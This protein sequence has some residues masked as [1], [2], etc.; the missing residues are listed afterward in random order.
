M[1]IQGVTLKGITV[2][3][4]YIVNQNLAIRIDANNSSLWC[5]EKRI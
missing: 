2:A 5:I 4:A 1:I 3:D